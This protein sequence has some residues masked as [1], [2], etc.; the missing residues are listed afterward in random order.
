MLFTVGL[1][2][3]VE[4]SGGEGDHA[5]R[6]VILFVVTIDRN[7]DGLHRGVC[8][9]AHQSPSPR[10]QRCG[11]VPLYSQVDVRQS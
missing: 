5:P 8:A 10:S 9:L 7:D 3:M 1:P 11:E 2:V 6:T 4:A